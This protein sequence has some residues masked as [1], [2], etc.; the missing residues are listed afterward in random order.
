MQSHDTFKINDVWTKYV[1][2]QNTWNSSDEYPL[3][4]QF[5]AAVI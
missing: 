1:K 3:V 2:V 4:L 5:D